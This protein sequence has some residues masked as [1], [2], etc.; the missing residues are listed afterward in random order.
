MKKLGLDKKYAQSVLSKDKTN[1]KTDKKTKYEIN[2]IPRLVIYSIGTSLTPLRSVD[3]DK[4]IRQI[5][6]Q[7]R[8]TYVYEV[9]AKLTPDALQDQGNL[10]I[11]HDEIFDDDNQIKGYKS[12]EQKKKLEV[13]IKSRFFRTYCASFD[14]KKERELEFSSEQKKR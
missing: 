8:Q 14:W 10:L 3:I 1:K 9:T 2:K 7:D 4:K 13:R 6:G 5:E 12:S 11:R